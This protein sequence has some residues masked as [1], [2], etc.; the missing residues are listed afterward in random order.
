MLNGENWIFSSSAFIRSKENYTERVNELA[1]YIQKAVIKEFENSEKAPPD[2]E[3]SKGIPFQPSLSEVPLPGPTSPEK[4][5]KMESIEPPVQNLELQISIAEVCFG[6]PVLY[7][8][9]LA[10]PFPA[11]A[12]LSTVARSPIL[13]LE[14]RLEDSETGE[15][16]GE[17]LD[18]RFPRIK[19]I[20]VNRLTVDSAVHEMSDSFAHDLVASFFRKRGQ[21]VSRP[22]PFKLIPW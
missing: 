3:I 4:D 9:L 22:F 2:M 18:R 6:D 17:L 14:A 5:Q 16:I 7:G 19:I 20:D 12:N 11:A 13:I 1:D 15:T 21:K 8:G 10:V